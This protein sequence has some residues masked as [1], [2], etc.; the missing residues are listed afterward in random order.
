M[1][2]DVIEY[3]SAKTGV[4][5]EGAYYGMWTFISKLGTALAI[6]VSGQI[7]ELG[8][9]VSQAGKVATVQPAS[10]FGAIRI[11]IGPIPVV[12]LLAAIV[13]VQCYPLEKKGVS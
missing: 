13:V 10:V 5:N 3:Q 7:L 6:F 4:R 9:Y 2:P 11:I 12:I 8:G 1:V